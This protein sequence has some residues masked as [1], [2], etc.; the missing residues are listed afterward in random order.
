MIQ[1]SLENLNNYIGQKCLRL[2]QSLLVDDVDFLLEFEGFT[3]KFFRVNALGDKNVLFFKNECDFFYLDSTEAG[4]GY[5]LINPPKIISDDKYFKILNSSFKYNSSCIIMGHWNFAHFIWNQLPA[6][7]FISSKKDKFYCHIR[8]SFGYCDQIVPTEFYRIDEESSFQFKNTFFIGGEFLNLGT[9][10]LISKFLNLNLSS[11]N[12]MIDKNYKYIYLGIR[13]RGYRELLHEI[14]F[15]VGL[16][17]YL[18][19]RVGDLFFYVDGFSFSST[20][21]N[22]FDA[23]FSDI[24]QSINKIIDITTYNNIRSING[25]HLIDFWG[26]IRDIDFYITHEGTMHHKL[27]WLYKDKPGL[28]LNGSPYQEAT[29]LW[30]SLQVEGSVAPYYI[31]V[32]N[33]NTYPENDRNSYFS[34]KSFEIAYFNIFNKLKAHI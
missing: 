4:E 20:N 6:F 17:D 3:Y 30:H 15:Y 11:F 24:N 34:F 31:D 27:G 19:S 26:Y 21:S 2:Y 14:E 1:Y 10:N 7:N 5:K 13:G 16:I 33:I 32:N 12:P 25:L 18:T 8:N 28:I 29:S 22:F 9:Y 23:R